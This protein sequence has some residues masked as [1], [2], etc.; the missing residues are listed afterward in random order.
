MT[1]PRALDQA[2]IPGRTSFII[3]LGLLV[4]EGR[5]RRGAPVISSPGL[6]AAPMPQ[7][8]DAPRDL[9]FGLLALQNALVSRDQL[10]LAFAS[11]TA[12]PG[13]PLAILL[14]EQGALRPEHRPLLDALV[15][16]HLKLHG[17]DPER[18]LAALEV[19]RS[20]RESLAA[21]G[22]VVEATLARVGAGS[23]EAGDDNRT[24]SYG[25]GT[26]GADADGRRFRVLRP[27][28]AGG[29]G[30]VYVALDA[31]LNREVALKQI[32][33]RHAD[34][35]DS[36]RRFLIEAEITGGLEHPGIVP[37][38]G[39]GVYEDGRP[40]Y[41]MRFI[42]GDSLKEA[43]ERFHAD[44]TLRHDPG[45]RSLALRNLLGR[46]V[47]V[48]DAIEYA[49]TRGVLHRDIK[50]GNV[51]VGKHGET[52]VVDWGLAKPLGKSE[53]SMGGERTLMPSSA[54]GSAETLPGS[55]LG[56][57]AYMSPEQAAGEL[58]H[59]GP[60]CDVYSLGATLYCLLTGKPPFEGD[61][62]EILRKVGRGE[63]P[64]PRQLEPGI[65]PAL[66][67][68]CLKAMATRS[69]DRYATCRAL[70]FDIERWAAD[71]PVSVYRPPA[72]V[73]L[74]RWARKHRTGV[75]V[76]AALF[77]TAVVVLAVSTVLL[78]Q[79]RARI[80]RERRAAESARARAQAINSFLVNDLLG[81]ADPERNPAG[82]SVTVRQL[83][84]RAAKSLARAGSIA[85]EPS[86]EGAVR[87]TIGNAYLELGLY[88]EAVE[89][90][91]NAERLLEQG[92][93]PLED[94]IFAQNRQ[95]WADAMRGNFVQLAADQAFKYSE[96]RLGRE[97]P[98]TVYAADT[99]A[100]INRRNP[101]A[102]TLLRENLEVQRRRL[103]TDHQLALRAASQLVIA[104]SNAQTDAALDEAENL[105]RESCEQWVR[106][107]GPEF[108][109]TL[110]ALAQEGEILATRG[111]LEE[112]RAVLAPLPD[113]YARVFG[114]DHFQRG[115][116]LRNYGLMLEATGDLDGAE[117]Q[118]RKSLAV[119]S[120]R[121]SGR[122]DSAQLEAMM[123]ACLARVE[124]TRGHDAAAVT[125]LLPI[126]QAHTR[127]HPLPVPAD[128][129]AG[130][131]ADALADRG[132]A[133]AAIELLKAVHNDSA[134]MEARLDWLLP[135][136]RSLIGGDQLRLGDRD[137][138]TANLRIA[139][140]R[141]DQSHLK[142]PAP[143]LAAARARLAR[144]DEAKNGNGS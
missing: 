112:A 37:V 54:S 70:A 127:S 43:I 100:Q 67:A 102:M 118:Y 74:L 96:D 28:A 55:A 93:A 6:G 85:L 15:D 84:D 106:R 33:P 76:G 30:A 64:R 65:D 11:W 57:P 42:R 38:Y 95:I 98:E 108:P 71:E 81:Q 140:E 135:H 22:P 3:T 10:V 68:V 23:I 47:D 139:V 138:A 130:A 121:L 52:L 32:L 97:H 91:A 137:K 26:A 59:L 144:L 31:E 48:C 107:Y 113:A 131:L 45:R 90:L 126:L 34:D 40:Y 92:D 87:S 120:K 143:V 129:L 9:L 101:K 56:T 117:A 133:K 124:L 16:A 119:F 13:K 53:S 89:Q 83:L 1:P 105:A 35:P 36:R 88:R 94:I 69:E 114:P 60:R 134:R 41:A 46:L 49:H 109:E 86:V 122:N 24:T 78:I 66:E 17:G 125:A 14:A 29:L 128:R 19:N 80:D 99:W 123:H 58:D 72:S 5:T 21:G 142:P 136:L 62:G 12:A 115:S 82:E 7:R 4:L 27:H 44:T 39:L 50:P 63:F 111:K 75:A 77:Q 116:V 103:G 104:L 79:S 141:L 18:S 132:D 51:I 110:F 25:G 20:T 2:S 8:G 73:R 61:V